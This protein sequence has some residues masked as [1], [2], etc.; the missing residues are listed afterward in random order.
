MN[1]LS[2]SCLPRP[3]GEYGRLWMSRM[4]STA[5]LRSSAALRD[6]GAPLSTYSRSGRPRRWM[7]ARSTSWPARVF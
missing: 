4:P 7:A 2:R 1:R 5:Q 3:S 6:R